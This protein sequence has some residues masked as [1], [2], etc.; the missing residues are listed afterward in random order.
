[1]R[2]PGN[3][4]WLAVAALG[5]VAYPLAVYFGMAA[6]PPVYL[7]LAAL[8]LIALRIL[9]ARRLPHAPAWMAAFAVAAS[10]LAGL[11]WRSPDLAVKA[12]PVTVSLAVAAI[13]GLSL[14][15]PPTVVERIARLREP[16]LPPEGVAYT[17]TVTWLWLAFL[18]ANAAVSAAT[19]LWGSIEQWTLW[20]GLLSYLAMGTLFLGE[21]MVRR[22]L[23]SRRAQ[24]QP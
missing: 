20:N 17:R 9:A 12:Y 23:R 5:G 10:A 18:L 6:V 2:R 16:D 11:S 7:V 13:F 3:N 15:F 24:S 19:A 1:M 21:V 22:R 4:R 14:R 8:G